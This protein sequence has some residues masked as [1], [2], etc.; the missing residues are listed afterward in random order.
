MVELTVAICTAGERPTLEGALTSVMTQKLAGSLS[1][2]VIVVDNSRGLTGFVARLVSRLSQG[3]PIPITYVREPRPGLGFARNAAMRA[4]HGEIVAYLDDDALAD[5]DWAV[6]LV[7]AY[8]ETGAAAI[9][10]RIDPIWG[11]QRP[12]W[13]GEELLGYLSLLDWGPSRCECHYPAY[14]YGANI[15]F[16][17]RALLAHE[18]FSTFLGVGGKP[19]YSMEE[20]EICRR[21]EAAGG[22]VVYSP[23]A[24]VRHLVPASRLTKRYFLERAAMNGR[25]TARMV[26]APGA[27][28]P[29]FEGLVKGLALAAGRVLRHAAL[30]STSALL[31]REKES[32]SQ[33]RHLCWNLAWMSESVVIAMEMHPRGETVPNG[34]ERA[35]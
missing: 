3:S 1:A 24:R 15:S 22:R 7:R 26:C 18:G 25:S 16:L 6:E 31:G 35:A 28:R 32:L 12:D 21:I 34:K 29:S 4:A 20:T 11:G 10:G 30:A 9:G 19:S 13:L 5:P 2:E 27:E 33:M 23:H 8:R 14:P 17:Q